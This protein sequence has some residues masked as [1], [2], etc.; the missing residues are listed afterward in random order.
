MEK[1]TVTTSKV[2]LR[3]QIMT[4]AAGH[5]LFDECGGVEIT[6]DQAE[7]IRNVKHL[8]FSDR[9][10][11]IEDAKVIDCDDS[12]DKVISASTM[13][14]SFDPPPF[15]ENLIKSEE[16]K[17]E[18]SEEVEPMEDEKVQLSKDLKKLTI[19]QLK[20]LCKEGELKTKGLKKKSELIDLI[21][22]SDIL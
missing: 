2:T 11:L 18:V 13:P 5:I 7:L 3:G 1:V 17:E 6:F 9:P 14:M 22:K 16:A 8:S 21:I 19:E 12:V 20:D 15:L 10:D 4:C